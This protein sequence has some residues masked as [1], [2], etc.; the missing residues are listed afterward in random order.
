MD[1][2]GFQVPTRTAVLE[3]RRRLRGVTHTSALCAIVAQCVC[4]C[5]GAV[6]SQG[7]QGDCS[8]GTGY[9]VVDVLVAVMLFFSC[10]VCWC[11]M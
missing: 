5:V 11:V 1:Q 3:R 7:D 10:S 9:F 6:R 8:R 2:E 4:A